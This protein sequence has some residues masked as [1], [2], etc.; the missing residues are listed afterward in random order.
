VL[1]AVSRG[2]GAINVFG[3]LD[4]PAGTTNVNYT[5]AVYA[6]GSCDPSGFGEGQRFVGS[7]TVSLTQTSGETFSF[8]MPT[9]LSF[10]IG[11]QI[12]ATASDPAG[13]TSEFSACAPL[14]VPQT[15][16]VTKTADTNDGACDADCSLREAIVAANARVGVDVIAFNI[17]GA[18]PHPIAPSTGPLPTITDTVKIDG[19]TQPG[20]SPNTLASGD[21]ATILIRIDG[22]A[23]SPPARGIA[24][25]A[26][27][28]EVRGL[29]ITRFIG[30]F[31][32]GS[33]NDSAGVPCSA[34]AD[35]I[36]A[37]NFI[38]LLPDGTTTM[39]N[40]TGALLQRRVQVGGPAPADRNVISANSVGVN[41]LSGA[42]GSEVDNNYIGTNAS[43][44]LDRGNI[45]QGIL[46][47]NNG[48][49]AIGL[50]APNRIAFNATGVLGGGATSGVRIFA[51]DFVANDALGIDLVP[52]GL[53]GDGV[54]PNDPEDADAGANNLQNFPVLTK[55]Q[56]IGNQVQVVGTLDVAAATNATYTIALYQSAACDASGNGEGEAFLGSATTVL[57]GSAETIDVLV[58]A[59]PAP[60]GTFTATATDS[61]GNTSEFSACIAAAPDL[62]LRDGFE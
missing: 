20:A 26:D 40:G 45:N 54:T 10:P 17:P 14:D 13:N 58:G 22:S 16:T 31:G 15:F 27:N 41:L 37:G 49:S 23:L 59:T 7:Q 44:T 50:G 12:T 47:N 4:V 38:G 39:G 48:S 29:S 60:G 8:T 32:I 28:S 35:S 25:C 19:Y 62:L 57:T 11:S 2:A 33:G 52:S 1:T 43:G 61:L 53:N 18:G 6:N 42:A 21:N 30:G 3:T 36:V 56:V 34:G 55:V 5:I 24:I 9:A 51:N 46:L